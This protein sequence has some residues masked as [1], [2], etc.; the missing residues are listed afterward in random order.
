MGTTPAVPGTS[1]TMSRAIIGKVRPSKME[2]LLLFFALLQYGRT[3]R[4]FSVEA[5]ELLQ[6]RGS[7]DTPPFQV[8]GSMGSHLLKRRGEGDPTRR[9]STEDRGDVLHHLQLLVLEL[10]LESDGPLPTGHGRKQLRSKKLNNK[11]MM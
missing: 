9:N 1:R 5:A 11:D 2:I 6:E 7:I 3:G 10:D 4:L 8:V